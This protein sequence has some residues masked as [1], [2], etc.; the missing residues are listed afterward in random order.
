[1]RERERGNEREGEREREGE[2][3]GEGE[4]D[5]KGS[6]G[7]GVEREYDCEYEGCEPGSQTQPPLLTPKSEIREQTRI[8]KYQGS[9]LCLH[10]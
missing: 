9:V 3:E 1:M 5:M 6:E 2:G 8:T 7:G 10:Y 4:G